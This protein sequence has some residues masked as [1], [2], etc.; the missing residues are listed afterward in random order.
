MVHEEVVDAAGEAGCEKQGKIEERAIRVVNVQ[1]AV[2]DA[3]QEVV[4][5]VN[6]GQRAKLA[7]HVG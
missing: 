5:P 4:A 2:G 1:S 7:H 3:G 6:G